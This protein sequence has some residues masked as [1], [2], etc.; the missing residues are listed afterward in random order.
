MS[1]RHRLSPGQ[2][3]KIIPH[4][5]LEN[6]A[7]RLQLMERARGNK[8]VQKALRLFCQ[9]DI[10]FYINT[11]V[12][13]FNPKKKKGGR[14]IGP[15]ITWDYQDDALLARPETWDGD[16]NRPEKGILWCFE[17]DRTAVVEKSR[18]MGASWLFLI[19]QD[20]LGLFHNHTQ[21]LNISKSADA[22]DCK[23]PDSLFWKL[24]F[25]HS[26][27]P[28]WLRGEIVENQMYMEYKRT[29]SY[30]TGEASTGRAGVGGR[31]AVI[32][33]DE[34]SQIKED[35]EVRQRTAGTADCRF[36][37]GTHLGT[38]T[39][40]YRLT[41]S[42]EIVKIQMHWSQ[43][44]DK[45]GGLYRFDPLDRKIVIL[46]KSF[47]FPMDYE[48]VK[49]LE[50]TG[51][52]HPGL[53]SPWYDWKS[54]D[55]GSKRGVAMELDI[56]PEG[57]ISQFIDNPQML[58]NLI[59]EYCRVPDWQGNIEYDKDT[60]RPKQLSKGMG[61]LSLWCILRPDGTP[62]PGI[63]KIGCDLS[64]GVGTSNSVLSIVLAT[65]GEKVGEFVSPFIYPDQMA[66][67]A[68]ALGWLFKTH[69]GDGAQILWENRGPGSPFREKLVALG[70]GNLYHWVATKTSGNR[71]KPVSEMGFNVTLDAK[72]KLLEEYRRALQNRQFLNHSEEAHTGVPFI[73]VQPGRLGRAFWGKEQG[74][75]FGSQEQPRRSGAG[76]RGWRGFWRRQV[77]HW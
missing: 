14:Q 70:Y 25:M 37:N 15:F 34:F 18:E 8:S 68:V 46:D 71:K 24:R 52:P 42:P 76:G 32:F 41:E 51:G 73:Q 30:N 19:F 64:A 13:Q 1:S 10:L 20:W 56:N 31:A 61:P 39:E 63:Y 47:K 7:Y 75:A 5:Y 4:S 43:H 59:R 77:G 74:R 53:R 54:K 72:R 28:G 3:H 58:Y 60:A 44:P 16:P 12:W 6:V 23:S 45:K 67:I 35:A 33:V 57:S 27:L 36:F 26:H 22:V 49:S 62:P 21:C 69:D 55:I 11:F 66:Y 17:H 9:R 38:D 29:K 40:F 65:T 50:P 48:F 2:W